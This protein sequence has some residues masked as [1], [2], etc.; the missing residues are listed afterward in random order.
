MTMS[1]KQLA[2]IHVAA[3]KLKLDDGHYRS[4]LVQIGGATSSKD[5]DREGFEA[6]MGYFEYLGF[7]PLKAGGADYGARPGM[8]SFAQ[9]E[10]IRALWDEYTKFEG[11]ADCLNKWVQRSFKVSSLRF[12]TKPTAQKAITALKKMKARERAA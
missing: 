9:L 5:L 11:S 2:L 6:L 1:R 4:A 8:A 10:L 7:Q 3:K 12:L